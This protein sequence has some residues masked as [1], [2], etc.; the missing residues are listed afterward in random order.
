MGGQILN[1]T[2]MMAPTYSPLYDADLLKYL[3]D[4]NLW[5]MPRPQH[6]NY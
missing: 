1:D 2:A 5:K 4:P 3:N 6:W